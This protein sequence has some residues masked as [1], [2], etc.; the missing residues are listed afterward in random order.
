MTQQKIR[1]K[2]T[3]GTPVQCTWSLARRGSIGTGKPSFYTQFMSRPARTDLTMNFH[4]PSTYEG[5]G[6]KNHDFRLCK[7]DGDI[8]SCFDSFVCWSKCRM[9]LF[10]VFRY[11]ECVNCLNNEQIECIFEFTDIESQCYHRR[12]LDGD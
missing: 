9:R 5:C 2:K 4:M 7:V 10:V 1:K 8:H 3:H 6:F 11:S 12:L